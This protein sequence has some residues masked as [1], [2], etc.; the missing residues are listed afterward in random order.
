MK[1]ALD[2]TISTEQNKGNSS[3]FEPYVQAACDIIEKYDVNSSACEAYETAL[4]NYKKSTTSESAAN[5]KN[6]MEGI[7]VACGRIEDSDKKNGKGNDDETYWD[8]SGGALVGSIVGAGAGFGLGY[9]ITKAVQDAELD[10][11]EQEA[12]QEFMDNVG[13]KIRCYIGADEVG[14]YGDVISTSME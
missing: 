11:A 13:S 3:L 1:T 8:K 7:K 12:I 4:D 2:V 10:K 14:T 9:G 6:Q 5:V